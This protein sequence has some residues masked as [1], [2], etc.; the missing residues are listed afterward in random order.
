MLNFLRREVGWHLTTAQSLPEAIWGI[1]MTGSCGPGEL[2]R[3]A[4]AA[5]HPITVIG[6]TAPWWLLVV[7]VFVSRPVVHSLGWILSPGGLDIIV[8]WGASENQRPE[9]R[10]PGQLSQDSGVERS[11]HQHPDCSQERCRGDSG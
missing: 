3:I 1:R 2:W 4:T 7:L 6:S 9:V 10:T 11:Y 8:T 5:A